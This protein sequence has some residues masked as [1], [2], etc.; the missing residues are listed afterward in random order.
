MVGDPA[1]GEKVFAKCRSCHTIDKG[2]ANGIGP[3]LYGVPGEQ[4]ANSADRGG[5]AFSDALKAHSGDKWTEANLDKWLTSPKSFADGTK[6]TFAGLPKEQDRADVIA[7]LNSQG[8][9]LTLGGGD[10]APAAD[11][12]KK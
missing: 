2:G 9:S 8:G 1:K 3:N 12:E 11:A 7:Y 10:A 4:I 5:F 6:M